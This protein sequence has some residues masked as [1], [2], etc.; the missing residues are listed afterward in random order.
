MI[1]T[2]KETSIPVDINK[3]AEVEPPPSSRKVPVFIE[4]PSREAHHLG[5][6]HGINGLQLDYEGPYLSEYNEGYK[7]GSFYRSLK[8]GQRLFV[9]RP[10]EMPSE[11]RPSNPSGLEFKQ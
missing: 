7:K 11:R 4:T 6:R 2:Q 10:Q 1:P 8:G 3:S 5:F 9:Y